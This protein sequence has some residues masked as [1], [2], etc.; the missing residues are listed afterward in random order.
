[1]KSTGCHGTATKPKSMWCASGRRQHQLPSNALS[2]DGTLV[3][4]VKSARDLGICLDSYLLTA[5]S[6]TL[7]TFLDIHQLL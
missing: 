2:I 6:L 4:P 3:D 7:K 5:I 1:M